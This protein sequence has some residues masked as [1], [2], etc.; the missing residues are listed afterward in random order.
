MLIAGHRDIRDA[1]SGIDDEIL[2]VANEV[3]AELDLRTAGALTGVGRGPHPSKLI[4]LPWSTMAFFLSSADG[5]RPDALVEGSLISVKRTAATAALAA[6]AICGERPITRVSLIGCGEANFETLRFLRHVFPQL[7]AAVVCDTDPHRVARFVRRGMHSMAGLN[8]EVVLDANRAMAGQA[9]I[10]VAT[11][12][13]EPNLS[14]RSA[15]ERAVVLLLSLRDLYPQTVIENVNIVDHPERVCRERSSLDIATRLTAG[16][17]FILG[18]LGE[19][20]RGR[21]RLDSAD[22]RPIIFSPAGLAEVDEALG[23]LALSRIRDAGRGASVDE[24][25]PAAVHQ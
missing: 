16:R 23:R 14:L 10:S 17:R 22:R 9:L 4:P 13:I 5:G 12:A 7:T 21:M 6:R 24:F 20:L 25:L 18:T 15:A 3:Y 2:R 8:F 19:L 1:L 11:R